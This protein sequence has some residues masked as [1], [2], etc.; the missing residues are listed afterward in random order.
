MELEYK[1]LNL[2]THAEEIN[3]K[4]RAKKH[5]EECANDYRLK[6]DRLSNE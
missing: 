3:L 4:Q 6:V 1:K 5:H 2:K